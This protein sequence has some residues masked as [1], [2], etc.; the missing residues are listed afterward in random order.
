[1][2]GGQYWLWHAWMRFLLLLRSLTGVMTSTQTSCMVFVRQI[3]RS[4]MI[5]V[6]NIYLQLHTHQL[7]VGKYS[8]H[9]W[10]GEWLSS[11]LS[12]TQPPN[13][14]T[15]KEQWCDFATQVAVCTYS[16]HV[17]RASF[18]CPT[19]HLDSI[20]SMMRPI[21]TSLH[22][23]YLDITHRI[24][25][26]YI[27]QNL[28]DLYGKCRQ[29][30]HTWILWVIFYIYPEIKTIGIYDS[31]LRT[32]WRILFSKKIRKWLLSALKP[33]AM[34]GIPTEKACW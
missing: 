30:Y 4:H 34:K 22:D 6:R 9:G 2:S 25:V 32:W 16:E 14:V 3:Y 28:V 31:Y 19:S 1:M 15:R 11:W 29:I 33:S 27:Y 23:F 17:Q 24:H 13:F 5:H 26:W 12:H 18:A 21:I 20:N 8:I 10:Y 7:N